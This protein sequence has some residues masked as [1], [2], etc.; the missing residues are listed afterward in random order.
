M[1]LDRMTISWDMVLNTMFGLD[2]CEIWC[3]DIRIAVKELI[4]WI[5]DFVNESDGI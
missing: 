3:Q 1:G 2:G 5:I 4:A